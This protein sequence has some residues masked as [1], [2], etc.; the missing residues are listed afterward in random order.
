MAPPSI[1]VRLSALPPLDSLEPEWRELE[2]RSD[3]PFFQTWSW[4]GV[5]LA[6]LP[7]RVR[8]RLL[9]ARRQGVTVGLAVLVDAPIRRSLVPFGRA[10]H[11]HTTGVDQ[12]DAITVEHNGLAADR[13]CAAEVMQAAYRHLA[14]TL[15]SCRRISLPLLNNAQMHQGPFA[16]GELPARCLVSHTAHQNWIVD[17]AADGAYLDSLGRDTRNSIRRTLRE[18]QALGPVQVSVAPHAATAL[19]YLDELLALHAQRRQALGAGSDFDTD[20]CL[21]FHRQLIQ[22]NFHR[23]EIQLLRLRVGQRDLGFLYS[24]VHR[25]RVYFYQ[26]GIDYTLLSR[27]ASPGLLLLASAVQ[28]NAQLGHQECDF[29]A[30]S[31]A[32][33][34]ALATRSETMHSLVLHRSGPLLTLERQLI[35]WLR[36]SIQQ[37][38]Q[39]HATLRDATTRLRQPTVPSPRQA[40]HR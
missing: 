30:G 24:F 32:Y 7:K 4:I 17:L 21:R 14:Q 3:V 1:D 40:A 37:V 39:A 15:S 33:K 11:L 6:S 5:W 9:R 26:M 31:M 16:A 29:L 25:G 2:T 13:S 12:L 35:G 18:A 8:P 38:R 28:H 34:Q 10:L 23:G 36:P 20:Y 19:A 27:K 22:Q